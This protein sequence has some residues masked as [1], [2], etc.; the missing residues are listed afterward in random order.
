MKKNKKEAPPEN[1]Q[2]RIWWV[3]GFMMV[4]VAVLFVG[5]V[6]R[7]LFQYESF[8]KMEER[9]SLRRV[10]L[11]APRGIITDRNGLV[12]A[13]NKPTFSLVVYLGE[14]RADFRKEQIRRVR[15]ARE[16]GL[17]L[18]R[19]VLQQNAI[20]TV[21]REQL[22]PI[23]RFL[24]KK[25]T[26]D[27][28]KI[29]QHLMQQPL[30]PYTLLRD[31][32]L[33][34]FA[35]LTELLRV[36]AP[37]QLQIRSLRQYPEGDTMSHVL[38]FVA[39][40]EPEAD[41]SNL[42][43]FSYKEQVGMNG[44]EKNFED[45]L[46]GEVGYELI[47]VNP[48]GFRYER[49]ERVNPQAGKPLQLTLDT[50]LQKAVEKSF[51]KK[52]GAAVALDV[53]TGE[54]LSLVSKP[55]Y[56]PNELI[57]SFSAQ[58]D[59]RIRVHNGWINRSIQGLY[60]PGSTFKLVTSLA[61]MESGNLGLDEIL[62]CENY[63]LVGGRKFPEHRK[64]G[65]GDINVVRALEVS[66]NVFFYQTGLRTGPETIVATAK[67]YGLDEP[68]GIELPG[69]TRRMI[70]PTPAWK[71]A[72]LSEP[73]YAGDTANMA[74]GQGYVLLTP[75]QMACF[76]A[77]LARG[78]T[79][80]RP[81]LIKQSTPPELPRKP[82]SEAVAKV[83]EGMKAAATTGTAR[84]VKVD[85]LTIAGKTGT[86]QIVVH[87]EHLTLAWFVGFAPIENP[88]VA[89]AVVVEGT[90]PDDEYAGG[91]IA[92]PVARSFFAE[93]KKNYI[94]EPQISNNPATT[95]TTK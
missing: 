67:K 51:G 39:L 49:T 56:N 10:L 11:P 35:R 60:P 77:S 88:Q 24:N 38:G 83:I 86:A 80:T 65:Y 85:G 36:D 69:E 70:L 7:Q 79:F 95:N 74:I 27:L 78:D 20:E 9:Q 81:T 3:F 15:A 34:E 17:T 32:S 76:T 2:T 12:L 26:L 21:L 52:I 28:K 47:L 40:R 16:K 82:Y 19:T 93:W 1:I 66:A 72:T 91:T 87:G 54:V 23:E 44:V 58:T 37:I 64:T 14:L 71:R 29:E 46:Q 92:A 48:G 8:K 73:W 59:A 25:V 33:E 75:M 62:H 55:S 61:A 43:T 13:K 4:L 22:K 42:R 57:P 89:I 90:S 94:D 50:R 63:F 41:E 6:V 53:S 68:T 31:I 30:M 5:L 18:D 45:I 84:L